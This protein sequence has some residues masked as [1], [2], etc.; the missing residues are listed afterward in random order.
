ML[1]DVVLAPFEAP[2]A[3]LVEDT[4]VTNK[5]WYLQ[6]S[7]LFSDTGDGEVA[8]Y[9]HLFRMQ[10]LPNRTRVFDVGDPARIVYLV[11][12]GKV[13]IARLTPDGKEVTVAVLGSGDIFGEET[14]FDATQPR[15]TIAICLE[16]TLLCMSRADELLA[17]LSTDPQIALNVA[18]ILSGRLDDASETIEDVA[19]AKVPDRI[20][21]FFQR[22]SHEHGRRTTGGIAIDVALTHG[23]IASAVGSTRE[24][25]SLELSKLVK[26][27]RVKQEGRTFVLPDEVQV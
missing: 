27:G 1:V 11:K 23:D 8:A 9:Q 13:R 20:V 26:A 17:L 5:V 3:V 16:E 24:T 18:K 14:L 21:H 2:P 4:P 22:L 12:Y 10:V 25:V 6:Q 7:R 19:F 15:S